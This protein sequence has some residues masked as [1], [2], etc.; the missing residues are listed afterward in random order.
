MYVVEIPGNTYRVNVWNIVVRS[1]T[2]LDCSVM[3][4]HIDNP[5]VPGWVVPGQIETKH[6]EWFFFS[7]VSF[8]PIRL[9]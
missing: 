5:L 7:S 4:I 6:V 2:K 8:Y 9:C 1:K 3:F